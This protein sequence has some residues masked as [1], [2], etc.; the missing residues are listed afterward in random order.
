VRIS[1][2]LNILKIIQIVS[3]RLDNNSVI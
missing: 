2:K 3:L 1:K